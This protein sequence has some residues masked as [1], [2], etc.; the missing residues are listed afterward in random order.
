MEMINNVLNFPQIPDGSQVH[1]AA[2]TPKEVAPSEASSKAKD[3]ADHSDLSNSREEQHSPLEYQLRLT[4]D[5]DPKTGDW[6][7]KAIDRYTGKVIRQLPRQ[8][9]LDMRSSSSYKAGSVIDT[10]A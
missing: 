2:D 10:E 6:V 7:Y 8:E 5:K 4:V 1:P 3:S 9:V